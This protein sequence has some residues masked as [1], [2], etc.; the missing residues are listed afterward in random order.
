MATS[1]CIVAVSS[2]NLDGGARGLIREEI[3]HGWISISKN[4]TSILS[5]YHQ[6]EMQDFGDLSQ[7]AV[8]V[9]RVSSST[10]GAV[11]MDLMET[12]N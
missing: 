11:C 9:L 5:Q 3:V 10:R 2:P 8:E 6:Q 12:P 4:D 1:G 7:N